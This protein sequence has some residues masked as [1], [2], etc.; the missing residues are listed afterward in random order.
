MQSTN[1]TALLSGRESSLDYKTQKQV[2]YLRTI[3]SNIP[4]KWRELTYAWTTQLR[5]YFFQPI[6]NALHIE[7]IGKR[8]RIYTW[9]TATVSDLQQGLLA[10]CMLE[11][12][13]RLV[14]ASVGSTHRFGRST[15]A[16]DVASAFPL[17][18][19]NL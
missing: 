1:P 6:Y 17:T 15:A 2:S 14:R 13:V 3:L 19:L 9:T 8:C 11:E 16:A 18:D 5:Y 7:P 12:A 4:S 10:P